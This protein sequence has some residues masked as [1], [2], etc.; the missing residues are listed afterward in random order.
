MLLN[1]SREA[2]QIAA[3]WLR[4]CAISYTRRDV[5]ELARTLDSVRPKTELVVLV[6]EVFSR[7]P[8]PLSGETVSRMLE[9][10]GQGVRKQELGRTLRQLVREGVLYETGAGR[11]HLYH[12]AA[13]AHP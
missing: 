12:A 3:A 9:E 10:N 13:H 4:F 1:V 5:I 6:R 2:W 7:S 11:S 8:T